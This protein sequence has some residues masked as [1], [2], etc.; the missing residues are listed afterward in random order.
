[1]SLEA[2]LTIRTTKEE[3][4]KKKKTQKMCANITQENKNNNYRHNK[5]LGMNDD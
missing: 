3:R 2:L 1:M 5:T 4:E